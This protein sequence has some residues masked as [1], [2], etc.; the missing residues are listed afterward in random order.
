MIVVA[1]DVVPNVP[2][3]ADAVISG[4]GNG[5]AIA[6]FVGGAANAS[7]DVVANLTCWCWYCCCYCSGSG[8]ATDALV[9]APDVVVFPSHDCQRNAPRSNQTHFGAIEN[10]ISDIPR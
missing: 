3:A 6:A 10:R 8:A 4:V 5:V 1:D 7:G 2:D 9:V